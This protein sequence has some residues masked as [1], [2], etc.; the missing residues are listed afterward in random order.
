MKKFIAFLSVFRKTLITLGAF[1]LVYALMGIYQALPILVMICVFDR[2]IM[3]R[4]IR[5]KY[6]SV[7]RGMPNIPLEKMVRALKRARR[8]VPSEM[9]AGLLIGL[10]FL[11]AALV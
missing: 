5:S 7:R 10:A 1:S 4:M 8:K 2:I 3:A 9:A 11:P 6:E